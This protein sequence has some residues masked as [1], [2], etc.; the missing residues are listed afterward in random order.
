DD[1]EIAAVPPQHRLGRGSA[2]TVVDGGA[3]VGRV[4]VAVGGAQGCE[5]VHHAVLPLHQVRQRVGGQRQRP[6]GV[7]V[8]QALQEQP[9][10]GRLAERI[11][12]VRGGKLGDFLRRV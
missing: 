5:Q 3:E 8:L 6:G 7:S 11:R 9:H 10:G 4:R 1:H 12:D 2:V